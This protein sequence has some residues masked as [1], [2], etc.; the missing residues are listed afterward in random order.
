MKENE[1]KRQRSEEIPNTK[2]LKR[3]KKGKKTRKRGKFADEE[4]GSET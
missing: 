3:K 1:R 4:N 2:I